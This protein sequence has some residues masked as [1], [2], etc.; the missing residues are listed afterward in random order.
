M[1]T[2]CVCV[3]ASVYKSKIEIPLCPITYQ[4]TNVCPRVKA[5][6]QFY[7]D[8]GQHVKLKK[9][10]SSPKPKDQ[11]W[12]PSSLLLKRYRGLFPAGRETGKR[13]F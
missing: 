2:Q 8:F 7:G 12:D 1:H 11:L 6:P 5:D 3:R 13:K 9:S 4:T 10:V